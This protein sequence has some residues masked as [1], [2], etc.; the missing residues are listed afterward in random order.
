MSMEKSASDANDLRQATAEVFSAWRLKLGALAGGAFGPNRSELV[1]V[2]EDGALR[3]GAGDGRRDAVLVLPAAAVLRPMVR[4]PIASDNVLRRA[5]GY[6]LE[7]LSPVPPDQVYFDFRVL[8]RD[9]AAKTAEIEL[10]I[11]RRDIV[12]DAVRLCRAQGL[13]AAAIRF[14]DDPRRADPRHFPVDRN[15]MLLSFWRRWSTALLGGAMLMLL[16]VV[17][18][19]AYLR[20]SSQLELLTDELLAESVRAAHAEHLQTR[21]ERA[22]AQLAFLAEQKRS[23]P[24]AA[25]LADIAHILPD[26][27]W[28]TELDISGGKI[29]VEGFSRSASD[30]IAV[31]DRSGHFTNAQ[32]AAPVTQS[33]T[34]GIERFDLTFEIPGAAK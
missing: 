3:P 8:G 23:P 1:A 31:F 5:L 15:A 34:P 27:S 10:R 22:S 25:I 2:Y 20:G 9:R 32:F 16:S 19:A 28:L 30:L 6:E 12:D 13:A 18:F 17:L 7:K 26:G 11:I 29:R 24:F 33:A 14:G 4:L 21:I